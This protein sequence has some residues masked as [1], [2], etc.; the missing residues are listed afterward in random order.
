M[1]GRLVTST[2]PWWAATTAS[3]I[4]SPSPV[5]AALAAC[6]RDV[7]ARVNRSNRSGS[8]SAGMPGPSSVTET[9][10]RGAAGSVPCETDSAPAPGSPSGRAS[11]TRTTTVV[12][13]GV[14]RP[15]LD[16][17]LP[18]TCRSRCSS[19]RTSSGSS[20]SSSTHR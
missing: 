12:P 10:S 5:E 11:L 3:T 17:R 7:S 19:P 4:A 9:T 18:S 2:A 14:C 20:G 6:E 8:K 13:S 1:P 15:A 16:S